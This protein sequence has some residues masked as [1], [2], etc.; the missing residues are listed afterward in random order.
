MQC[1]SECFIF[2][3]VCQFADIPFSVHLQGDIPNKFDIKLHRATIFEES[4][5]R[6]ISVRKPE[7]LKARLWIE[8]D[9]EKGLDY[10]GVARE[11]FLY[12]SKEMFNPYYGLFEYSATYVRA[13]LLSDVVIYLQM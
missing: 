9:G 7:Y 8:F 5:R 4:Y 1:T 13:L 2:I 12:L 6:I 10:G 3:I 11:W